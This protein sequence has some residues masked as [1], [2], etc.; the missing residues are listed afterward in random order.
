MHSCH[1][2]WMKG[3]AIL[4]GEREV[5]PTFPPKIPACEENGTHPAILLH[6]ILFIHFFCVTLSIS[7]DLFP[8]TLAVIRQSDLAKRL[9]TDCSAA[10]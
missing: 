2:M 7:V 4:N 10:I 9:Q 3:A 1:A 6:P 8:S 5:P